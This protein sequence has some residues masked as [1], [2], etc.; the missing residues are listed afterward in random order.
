MTM[1]P[2]TECDVDDDDSDDY[3]NGDVVDDDV[4]CHF[5]HNNDRSNNVADQ[6]GGI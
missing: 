6:K 5:Y 2:G 3:D 4:Y 1:I